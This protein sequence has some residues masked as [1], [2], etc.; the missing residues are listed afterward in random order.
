MHPFLQK[1]PTC[2]L[3]PDQ[4]A[5][6]CRQ[7][8][9]ITNSFM[10]ALCRARDM[11]EM[12]GKQEL[13]MALQINLADERGVDPTTG[14]PNGLGAHSSWA[15]IFYEALDEAVE[16]HGKT[17]TLSE[18]D[19]RCWE[20]F[21]VDDSDSLDLIIGMI[22][23]TEK[24][25]PLDFTAWLK[26]FSLGFPSLA[27]QGKTGPLYYMFDH[28]EHDETRHLPDLVDGYLGRLPGSK[29]YILESGVVGDR[30][31]ADLIDGIDRSIALRL[32]FY[33][34][35]LVLLERYIHP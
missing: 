6:L 2:S 35:M 17:S 3:A 14:Q 9:T 22:M 32:A 31:A 13:A 18:P 1:L 23:A 21:D 29:W 16:E 26:A 19:P 7:K 33:D 24:C 12:A 25:I 10:P 11:A 20:L 8:L 28:I 34:H 5:S 30:A 15:K 27:A 4:L